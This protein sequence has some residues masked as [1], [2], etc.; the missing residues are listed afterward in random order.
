MLRGIILAMSDKDEPKKDPREE[1]TNKEELYAHYAET[2]FKVYDEPHIEH[3]MSEVEFGLKQKDVNGND[4]PVEMIGD[5]NMLERM[6]I[7]L[8]L[9]QIPQE[10]FIGYVVKNFDI[11]FISKMVDRAK[12]IYDD[13][14]EKFDLHIAE[15]KGDT[16]KTKWWVL[17]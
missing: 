17:D 2:K 14:K 11:D 13:N 8:F 6:S 15:L 4:V 12:L 10:I 9:N 3:L 16:T 5:V 7:T 1:I